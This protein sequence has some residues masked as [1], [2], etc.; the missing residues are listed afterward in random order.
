[1]TAD[2]SEHERRVGAKDPSVLVASNLTEGYDGKDDLCRFIII[3]KV[4]YPNLGDRR[5]RLRMTEDGRS[6]DYH[7][8]VAVVQG[9]GRGV[10][11]AQDY[12]DTWILDG[13]WSMLY[14]KRK[15]WLPTSFREAYHHNVQLP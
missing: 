9:A 12:A 6:F 1:M 4:P 2:V 13:L 11:H 10:R 8:L 3:P 14:A 5:T 15:T 7:A